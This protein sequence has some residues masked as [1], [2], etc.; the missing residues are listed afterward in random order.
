MWDGCF[1]IALLIK[2]C[3]HLYR[4]GSQRDQVRVELES[5]VLLKSQS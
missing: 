1:D 4:L 2:Q 3:G 5:Q